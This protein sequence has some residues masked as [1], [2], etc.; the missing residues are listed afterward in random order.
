MNFGEPFG[1]PLNGIKKLVLG[2]L[3]MFPGV[4]LLLIP[5]I[6]A[7]GYLIRVAGD[8]VSGK[9]EL[10][11]FD[12][13]GNLFVKGIGSILISIIYGLLMII[14]LLPAI[15]CFIFAFPTPSYYSYSYP[16]YSYSPNMALIILAIIFFIIAF[17][18]LIVLS[19]MNIM[20]CVRY[21][22]KE[23]VGAA[24]ES[25]EIYRN[26]RANTGNYIIGI[27]LCFVVSMVVEVLMYLV[28]IPI[29]VGAAVGGVIGTIVG[30]IIALPIIGIL[31]FYF[32]LFLIRM[33]AQIY[34]ESKVKLGESDESTL[35]QPETARSGLSKSSEWEKL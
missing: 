18:L 6:I 15:L 24:F 17:I 32:Y 21:G 28:L 27:I 16:S 29:L 12:N 35:S 4:Y 11:E 7:G 22:E 14:L 25:T 8:T 1:Y 23:N 5:A 33:F 2:G 20:A 13:W 10:P 26:F 31:Y 30:I 9:N 19:I 3:M 34:K